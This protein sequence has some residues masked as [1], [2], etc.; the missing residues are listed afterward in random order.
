MA[1]HNKRKNLYCFSSR[2][3]KVWID[4]DLVL[5]LC[6]FELVS[7]ASFCLDLI[8]LEK[9]ISLQLVLR[10]STNVRHHTII[11]QILRAMSLTSNKIQTLAN[12]T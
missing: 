6:S 11:L 5:I 4:G 1:F 9:V 3:V 7:L 8:N 2:V 10:I 12:N